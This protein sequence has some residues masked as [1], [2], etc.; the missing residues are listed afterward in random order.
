VPLLWRFHAAHHVDVDLDTSTGL[1][2]HAGEILLSVPWRAI[3]IGLIGISP[4]SLSIW[5]TLMLVSIAF[6]HS[7]IA[8]S[9]SLERKLVRFFVTPRMHGI[10]HSVVPEEANSNWSSGLS[11]WDRIHGTM[12]LNIPQSQ[13]TIGLPFQRHSLGLLKALELP[14]VLQEEWTLPTGG[15]PDRPVPAQP[16]TFMEE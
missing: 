12:R 16:A 8:L 2:F 5:Q 3:Q 1:R 7:N 13:L 11:V 9:P 4:L 10:H 14:V 15:T 6:H